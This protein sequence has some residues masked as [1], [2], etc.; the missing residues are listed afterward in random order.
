MIVI[1]DIQKGIS[2]YGWIAPPHKLDILER[3][4]K[5]NLNPDWYIVKRYEEEMK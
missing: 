2:V 4:W 5:E 3:V 1:I